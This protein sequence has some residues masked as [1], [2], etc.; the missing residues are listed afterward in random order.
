[1]ITSDEPKVTASSRYSIGQTCAI[2][3]IDRKTLGRYTKSGLIKCGY[4]P[5]SL[6]K[7]Y[8]GLDIMKFWRAS[9]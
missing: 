1:M 2:L 7:F 6:R 4:R 9:V 5:Q 8:T 3:C